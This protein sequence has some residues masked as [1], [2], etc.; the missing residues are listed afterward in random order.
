MNQLGV[1]FAVKLASELP[2]FRF[3]VSGVREVREAAPSNLEIGFLDPATYSN[4][5]RGARL[6]VIPLLLAIGV[7]TKVSGALAYG[8]PVLV[9]SLALQ[10]FPGLRPWR[11]V[12][13]EDDPRRFAES[14]KYLLEDER[15]LKGL[16]SR[17]RAYYSSS[18]INPEVHGEV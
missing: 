4:Y 12:A 3:A 10:E 8:K 17:A 5:V 7:Q 9:T 16:S 18:P 1:R 15:A 6:I 11:E 14:I 2:R 13:V